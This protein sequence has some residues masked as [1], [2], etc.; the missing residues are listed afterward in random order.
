MRVAGLLPLRFVVVGLYGLVLGFLGFGL[1]VGIWTFMFL[2][3]S[4]GWFLVLYLVIDAPFG[5]GII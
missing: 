1:S 2:D 4:G 5:V 3:F